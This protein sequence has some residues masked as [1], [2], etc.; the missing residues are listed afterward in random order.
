MNGC[1]MR[2]FVKERNDALLSLDKEKIQQ[3]CN[4]YGI[5]IPLD[6][7]L[8]W[9]SVH[10][11]IVHLNAG[12]DEQKLISVVWLRQNGFSTIANI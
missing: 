4:K 3:Y 10:L 9:A 11:S 7:K 12:T 8:F 1:E 5:P 6:E 2:K